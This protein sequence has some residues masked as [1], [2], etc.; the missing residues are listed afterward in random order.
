MMAATAGAVALMA[1][2]LLISGRLLDAG[3][4][5][6]LPTRFP[7]WRSS[8]RMIQDHPLTGVGLDQFLYQYWRRYVEPVGWPERYTSHPHN[9]VLD[10][11]LSLGILGVVAFVFLA[12]VVALDARGDGSVWATRGF[13]LAGL[14]ALVAGMVH[15]LVDNAYFLPDLAVMTWLLIALSTSRAVESTADAPNYSSR[16]SDELDDVRWGP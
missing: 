16:S 10:V 12:V 1:L 4:R 5:G 13:E 14:S 11:W 9:L 8:L 7:I 2:L 15:G 3:G 6:E